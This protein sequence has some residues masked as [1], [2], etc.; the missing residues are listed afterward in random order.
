MPT[1][2][3]GAEFI[4]YCITKEGGKSVMSKGE[5]I[6][7]Q[8]HWRSPYLKAEMLYGLRVLLSVIDDV[9]SGHVCREDAFKRIKEIKWVGDL[10]ANHLFAVGVLRGI[11]GTHELLTFPEVATTLCSAVRKRLFDNNNGMT[12]DRIR[13]AT[14]RISENLGHNLLGGEHGLCEAMRAFKENR[15]GNDGYHRDQDFVWI[16]TDYECE[17][18]IIM[19]V[20]KGRATKYRKEEDDLSSVRTLPRDDSSKVKHRWWIPEPNKNAC[21]KHFVKECLSNG[22]NPME[23]VHPSAVGRSKSSKVEELELW[24]KY[25]TAPGNRINMTSLPPNLR[26]VKKGTKSTLQLTKMIVKRQPAKN[27]KGRDTS[28]NEATSIT[29]QKKRALVKHPYLEGNRG[30]AVGLIVDTTKV[31][32]NGKRKASDNVER[33]AIKR[34]KNGKVKKEAIRGYVKEKAGQKTRQADVSKEAIQLVK[35]DLVADARTAWQLG[36][37]QHLPPSNAFGD[38]YK[39]IGTVWTCSLSVPNRTEPYYTTNEYPPSMLDECAKALPNGD[40]FAFK[41]KSEAKNAL[42]WWIICTVPSKGSIRNWANQLL[43][44]NGKVVLLAN[45][46]AWCTL[47]KDNIGSISVEYNGRRCVLA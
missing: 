13:K 33:K 47:L 7:H 10:M 44:Q 27:S 26:N 40:G 18:S 42:L 20:I 12:D 11:I 6:R 38:S 3:V 32:V 24:N 43:G 4:Q 21:L 34:T 19:E 17:E 36:Y 22:S 29:Q 15:P 5:G 23:V 31:N 39:N 37:G 41:K 2:V 35:I 45:N 25:I 8:P 30:K 46:Q 14:A 1:D 16:S 9:N 28:Q